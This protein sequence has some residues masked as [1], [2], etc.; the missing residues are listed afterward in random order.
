MNRLSTLLFFAA[1]LALPSVHA[2][3]APDGASLYRDGTMLSAAAPAITV[4]DSVGAGDTFQ[5]AVLAWLH[6]QGADSPAGL[7]ALADDALQ[8]ML[9]FACRAAAITCTRRGPD[10]PRRAELD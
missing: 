2:A 4:C 9:D 8:R 6:E 1:A 5:A 7:E 10:L 3:G